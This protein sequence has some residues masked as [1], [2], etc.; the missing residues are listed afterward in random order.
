MNW[1][2]NLAERC[3]G[4]GEVNYHVPEEPFADKDAFRAWVKE[5]VRKNTSAEIKKPIRVDAEPIQL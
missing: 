5:V 2:L 1:S 4:T 3:K